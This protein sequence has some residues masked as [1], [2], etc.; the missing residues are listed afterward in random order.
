METERR[1]KRCKH[2]T[3]N[4]I[5]ISS[6]VLTRRFQHIHACQLKLYRIPGTSRAHTH[7]WEPAPRWMLRTAPPPWSSESLIQRWSVAWCHRRW[8]RRERCGSS[9]GWLCETSPGPLCPTPASVTHTHTHTWGD[10]FTILV[11]Y[12]WLTVCEADMHIINTHTH[13]E[14]RWCLRLLG[15]PL[16]IIVP[17]HLTDQVIM[18]T[19]NIATNPDSTARPVCAWT[20]LSIC[21]QSNWLHCCLDWNDK[22]VT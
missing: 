22:A 5:I 6:Y 10:S 14:Q 8:W 4:N 20:P 12:T 9:S 11:K 19:V 15:V 17:E 2:I 7:L 13:T 16:H 1:F 21:S 18:V 3:H